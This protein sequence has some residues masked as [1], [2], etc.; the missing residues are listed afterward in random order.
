[1]LTSSRL[2]VGIVMGLAVASIFRSAEGGISQGSTVDLSGYA[3]TSDLT[4]LQSTIMAAMP[5]PATVAPAPDS[6]AAVIGSSRMN[7]MLQDSV[8]PAR[9]RSGSCQLSSGACTI[10]WSSSFAATP[11]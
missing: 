11:N 4:A 1:M 10:N 9:Y 6:T 7:Y 2:L 8:R 5:Q 3:K